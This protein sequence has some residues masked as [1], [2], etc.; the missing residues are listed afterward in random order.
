M[1]AWS[2]LCVCGGGGGAVP[3]I[4]VRKADV[5]LYSCIGLD[6]GRWIQCF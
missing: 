2:Q 4:E 1:K 6:L 5:L 3:I